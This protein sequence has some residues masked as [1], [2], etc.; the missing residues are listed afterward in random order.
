MPV[1]FS[2]YLE[3][4]ARYNA[5]HSENEASSKKVGLIGGRVVSVADNR[6]VNSLDTHAVRQD[7][8]NSFA[9]EFGEELRTVAEKALGIGGEE[10]PLT[11]RMIVSL[12]DIGRERT[13]KSVA[14][15][16]R[17]IVL[18]AAKRS[19]GSLSKD[20]LDALARKYAKTPTQKRDFAAAEV[21][22]QKAEAAFRELGSLT[23]EQIAEV[24]TADSMKKLS[25][26][27]QDEYSRI[28][29][30]IIKAK[31]CQSMLADA[32]L[33][34]YNNSNHEFTE[35]MPVIL[36][37]KNRAA[38]LLAVTT[39]IETKAEARKNNVGAD[40]G[41]LQK[42]VAEMLPETIVGLHGTNAALNALKEHLN[43]IAERVD[44]LK[45]DSADGLAHWDEVKAIRKEL[46]NARDA[47]NIAASQG[48][49]YPGS[50]TVFKPDGVLLGA[51]ASLFDEIERDIGKLSDQYDRLEKMADV[52]MFF[53]RVDK[54]KL[55]S[56]FGLALLGK[57]VGE[58]T[59]AVVHQSMVQLHLVL[60]SMVMYSTI[61]AYNNIL[62]TVNRLVTMDRK[63]KETI[64]KA[65]SELEKLGERLKEKDVEPEK[66]DELSDKLKAM[67]KS[68]SEEERMEAKDAIREAQEKNILGSM[69]CLDKSLI[70]SFVE[71]IGED[72]AIDAR[73]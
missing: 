22:R 19:S 33:L 62:Q 24:L 72:R 11:S 65:V 46:A 56:G 38:E 20:E 44:R 5:T 67:L 36:R 49:K 8:I 45:A 7:F 17:D 28:F 42:T 50:D 66:W 70:M 18:N 53:P 31:S 68:M 13:K 47:L 57:L 71:R 14:S 2:K 12:N 23:G 4:A 6:N 58:E 10:K 21:L 54:A 69:L 61:L 16:L 15:R 55:F 39:N 30:I 25:P 35:L 48:V 29:E 60:E 3:V 1:E 59:A 52:D 51:L 73:R 43:P 32:L 26:K 64:K 27:K 41:W 9:A 34:L 37:C 40:D 63:T